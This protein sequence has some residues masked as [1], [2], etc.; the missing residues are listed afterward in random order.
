MEFSSRKARRLGYGFAL[1][2]LLAG[3]A[4]AVDVTIRASDCSNAVY[5]SVS[6]T[7][8]LSGC[9]ATNPSDPP[10]PP[11]PPA[12]PPPA[13][14]P[15]PPPSPGCDATLY[16][17]LGGGNFGLT[18]Q[19]IAEGEVKTYCAPLPRAVRWVRFEQ[20]DKC[21]GTNVFLR[22]IPPAG[23]TYSTGT[24]ILTRTERQTIQYGGTR[25]IP[26]GYIPQMTLI[27]EVHGEVPGNLCNGLNKYDLIWKFGD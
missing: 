20:S 17:P 27:V 15:P 25:G 24:P 26:A 7:I 8:N 6:R 9:G 12:P 5:D 14:P 16:V 21:L 19:V 4:Y 10:P 11:P 1:A 18:D 2:G 13:P 3:S 22:T 23:A